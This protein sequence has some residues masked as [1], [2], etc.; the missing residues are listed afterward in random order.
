MGTIGWIILV[1]VIL[2]IVAGVA[3]ALMGNKR[4]A[5]RRQEAE[6]IRSEASENA[7]AVEAQRREAQEAAAR[8]EVA[9]AEA[10]RAEQ[11]AAE[12]NQGVTVEE[13]RVED[14]LRTA[15]RVDPDVDT[16]A[17]DYRPGETGTTGGTTYADPDDHTATDVTGRPLDDSSS[18]SADPAHR[19]D[20]YRSDPT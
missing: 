18:T 14:R 7:A 10:A 15:D 2:V 11:A 1:I 5:A 8:A 13:A 3:Y 12:A 19:D 4:T 20:R 9:R 6:T 16:R 17:E